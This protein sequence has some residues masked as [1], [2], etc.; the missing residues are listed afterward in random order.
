M[1]DKKVSKLLMTGTIDTSTFNNTGVVVTNT[2]D[3]L[4]QYEKAIETYIRYSDFEY[5]VFS[6]NSGYK[7]D[8]EKF[9]NMAQDYNK[10][11]EFISLP[12]YYNETLNYGK[13]YGESRLIT[14]TINKSTLINDKDVIFKVTGRVYVKNINKL[15][16]KMRK[17]DNVF[18]SY[19]KSKYVLTSFFK[20]K[21]SDYN[22][23]LSDAYNDCNDNIDMNLESVYY[24][25][26]LKIKS[27]VKCF[28]YYPDLDG[29]IGGFGF[30][31]N[32]PKWNLF[33]RNI[34]I[35]LGF[36]SIR[37]GNWGM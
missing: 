15:I 19:N 30:K 29:I 21:V 7:F 37:E 16:K 17:Y 6:D 11:F 5:I 12:G 8:Y 10:E 4:N 20:V 34:L 22:R 25:R 35:K 1:N 33:I 27:R 3:R 9:K 23:I 2:L 31:Y 26:L 18:I 36:F 14:D 13:S 32:K 28:K 24:K